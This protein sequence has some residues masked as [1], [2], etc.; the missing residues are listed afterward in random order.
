MKKI[1]CM[2][3]CVCLLLSTL[4][5]G[6]GSVSAAGADSYT[7]SYGTTDGR[8]LS[9]AVAV[10]G[11]AVTALQN[12]EKA[13]TLSSSTGLPYQLFEVDTSAISGSTVTLSLTA[14]TVENERLA[15]KV[16]NVTTGAWD[17]VATAV[18][19]GQLTAEVALS[20][21][22][23]DD[24]L[25][26][27]VTVDFVAN[28]SNRFL[29]STDQQHYTEF[30]DLNE[31]YYAIH[32]HM[33]EEYEAGEVAYVIN[34]GDI[35]DDPPNYAA[36]AK[37]Q[38]IVADKAFQILDDANVPYGIETGNH[39]V[40]DYPMNLYN[41]YLQYF[42]ESRY[43][44]KP[45]YGGT[46]DN[47]VSHYDLITVGNV[48]FLIL[49]IGYGM[50]DDVATIAWANEVLAM[51]PHRNAIICT[52][53]YLSPT[54]GERKGRGE[55]IHTNIVQNNEN[56]KMVLSGH[57]DGAAYRTVEIDENRSVLE[58]M[59]DYQF[60]QK[61]ELDYYEGHVD[62]EHKIGSVKYCN[63]E[64]YIR[65]VIVNGDSVSMFAY[66][67]YTGGTTPFGVR[68]DFTVEVDFFETTRTITTHHFAVSASGEVKGDYLTDATV[69][70]ADVVNLEKRIAEAESMDKTLYT[71]DSYAALKDTIKKAKN[72]AKAGESADVALAW[73]E[74]GTA[75]GM[76]DDNLNVILREGLTTVH[77]FDMD[78]TAWENADGVSSLLSPS[79]N[80]S[81]EELES[82]G[83]I[84]K[85]GA[86]APNNW[87]QLKYSD[88][89]IF[90]PED[91]KVYLYLDLEAESTWSCYPTIIQNTQQYMG[92]WNYIIENAYKVDGDAGVGTYKGVYDVTQALIDMGVNPEEEMILTFAVN[93][94]PGAVTFNEIA[95]LT[96]E[97]VPPVTEDPAKPESDSSLWLWIAL[98][99]VILVGAVAIAAVALYKPKKKEVEPT[100]ADEQ[101]TDENTP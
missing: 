86:L 3:F 87:P 58:A 38:W 33:V 46:A 78:I 54:E 63:G 93:I 97:Y 11:T 100:P 69:L 23:K 13:L 99:G 35:V 96:G 4:A 50:E 19:K 28:G 22:A 20:D 16:Y 91:G 56:V 32:D 29:W 31:I 79:S 84:A 15:L 30:E 42:N 34:T 1:L 14:E 7:V 92:R 8:D 70:A 101:P 12:G 80:I 24:T 94:V 71:A 76:L 17:T 57:Y 40:G 67:P 9:D 6:F 37:K 89:I 47:N 64:G 82:G 98:G 21:Y 5:V 66:S 18:T 41:L 45:W 53:Q 74:L 25:K 75:I 95:L 2:A 49:Y 68:D 61:E 88:P 62:P 59:A 60:V 90:T 51:Y 10:D 81:V 48:D 36:T 73:A 52:H 85:K 39:D 83:F 77:D 72:V 65:E 26:A 43:I 44:D 55:F 27:M